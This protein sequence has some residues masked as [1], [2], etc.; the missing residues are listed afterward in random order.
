MCVCVCGACVWCSVDVVSW[1]LHTT[2]NALIRAGK[3]QGA[4]DMYSRAIEASADGPNSHVFFSNRAAA[5]LRLE[6]PELA[7]ADA[8][9]SVKLRPDYTKAVNRLG[10]ALMDQGRY[11]EAI[12]EFEE[13][14]SKNPDNDFAKQNLVAA[15]QKLSSVGMRGGW[16][17]VPCVNP[18]DLTPSVWSAMGLGGTKH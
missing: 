10:T 4:V 17:I 13:V 8:R 5:Y 1:P 7:E 12:A 16:C 6:K 2:G 18:V 9:A 3:F 15:R 14:V 11:A